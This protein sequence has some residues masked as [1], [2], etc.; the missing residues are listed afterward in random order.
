MSL[1]ENPNGTGMDPVVLFNI[2][3][4]ALA[5]G[6]DG[7]LG[8]I[9]QIVVDRATG[10]L[11]AL[12][13]RRGDTGTEVE[14]PATHIT[15][16]TGDQV[17]LDIGFQD[18]TSHPHLAI[19]Y[20]PSRYVP[21]EPGPAKPPEPEH[22]AEPAPPAE[23]HTPSDA[24]APFMQSSP[25]PETTGTLIGGKPSTGGYG[26]A[27]SVPVVEEW[28][29]EQPQP[30]TNTGES[31][32]ER[33]AEAEGM[34]AVFADAAKMA[35]PPNPDAFPELDAMAEA[36]TQAQEKAPLPVTTEEAAIQEDPDPYPEMDRSRD[37]SDVTQT[38]LPT[39]PDAATYVGSQ[40]AMQVSEQMISPEEIAETTQNPVLRPS[41]D[42]IPTRPLRAVERIQEE[43]TK[44][45]D[46]PP[47]TART[48]NLSWRPSEYHDMTVSL[49]PSG[50]M[51]VLTLVLAGAGFTAGVLI[52]VF[53]SM[54]RRREETSV[55]AP[56]RQPV[57]D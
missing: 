16:S 8:T 46:Q 1:Q 48:M 52:G 25:T 28:Q 13:L 7:L 33:S 32:Q 11:D 12:I 39:T 50:L 40:E 51:N 26:S 55:P 47:G 37:V 22:S 19:P 2:A 36:V 42:E 3:P 53:S 35:S 6:T 30:P 45:P 27:S 5:V 17:F 20:D 31:A 4:G 14:L 29:D 18:F 56:E 24:R 21:V 23:T 49:Q 44:R 15:R 10:G 54:R 9:A 41:P 43:D 38:A 34:R 57:V